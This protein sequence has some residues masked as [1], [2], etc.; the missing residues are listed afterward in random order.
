MTVETKDEPYPG[1]IYMDAMHFGMG[2]S[3]VQVTYETQTINHARYLYDMF[4]P[5]TPILAALSASAPIYKGK[6][7]DNDLRWT[8]IA[9]SVDDRNAEERNPSSSIYVAKSRYSTVN[10]YISN[11]E[12]VKDKHNDTVPYKVLEEH[13]EYLKT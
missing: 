11:H 7:A 6:L 3:C 5:F 1:Q 13:T 8:V 2:C 4:L 9:Q 10:H 12:Y